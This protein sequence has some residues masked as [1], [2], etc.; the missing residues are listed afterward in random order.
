MKHMQAKDEEALIAALP[1][2]YRL[3]MS[4]ANMKLTG[5][6]KSQVIIL[7][8]LASQGPLR[9]SQIAAYISSQKAQATRTVAILEEEG[10]IIRYNDPVNRSNVYV[11]LTEDGEAFLSRWK[12]ELMADLKRKLDE[13]VS[14]EEQESLYQAAVEMIKVLGKIK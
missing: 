10:Y 13:S 14:K 7:S 2:L 6:T 4:S 5:L 3:V 8:S 11:K 12:D 9:M 1:L